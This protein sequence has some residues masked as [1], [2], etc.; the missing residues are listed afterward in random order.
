MPGPT[1]LAYQHG[2]YPRPESLVAATRDLE[3]GRTTAA[4]VDEEYARA[5]DAFIAD[6]KAASLDYFSDGLLGWHDV[7][8][9]LVDATDGM[10]A[11][12]LVRWFDNNAFFR[13]PEIDGSPKLGDGFADLVSPGTLPEPRVATLPSPY[14]FSRA[15]RESRDRDRLMVDLARDI[16]AP[17]VEAVTG[18]GYRL[19]HL[20]EP[21]VPFFGMGRDS[22]TP[23][24]EALGLLRERTAGARLVLHTYFGDAGPYAERLK[25]LPVDAVGIDAVETDLEALP[26]PWETGLVV[27]CLDGRRSVLESPKE[28]AAL[29]QATVDRLVPPAIYL[30]SNSDLELLGHET[31]RKKVAILGEAA[32]LAREALS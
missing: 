14:L 15:V 27:G 9:P 19:V 29:I 26:T 6:Q 5:R 31:A 20:E 4:H 22:W 23:F 2:I 11:Q 25:T 30:S 10:Q 16:L 24:E 1:V 7:F 3:R 12:A 17:A 32:R 13:A 18:L 28:I 21:W 8:R